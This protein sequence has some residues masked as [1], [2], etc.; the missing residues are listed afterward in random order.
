MDKKPEKQINLF[1]RVVTILEEARANVVRSVNINMVLAYWLIGRE[2]IEEVQKGEKRAEYGK[3]VVENLSKQLTQKYGR[4]FA[5]QTLWN[6]RKFYLVYSDKSAILSP[7]GRE[8]NDEDKLSPPRRESFIDKLR[9]VIKQNISESGFGVN[10]LAKSLYMS[11]SSLNTKVKSLTGETPNHFLMSFRL[12]YAEILLKEQ[13]G[14][15]TEVALAS[16][17]TSSSYFTSCFKKKFHVLPTLY[18]NHK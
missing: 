11:S 14:N 17:F 4:G 16:G 7:T 3:N 10:K 8:L 15:V 6:F 5:V 9:D 12:Q 2:I 13:F 18:L 1:E